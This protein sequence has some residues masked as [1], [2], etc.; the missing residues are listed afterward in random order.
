MALN[1]PLSLPNHVSLPN[2]IAKAAMSEGLADRRTGAPTERLIEL[3]RRWARGGTGLL[4]T[5]NVQIDIDA[6]E[7]LGNVV[8]EDDRHLDMLRA[9]ADAAQADGAALWMQISHAGRQTPRR[10]NPSPVGPSAIAL[11]NVGGLA[12]KPRELTHDEI[13]A[14]IDRF[15]TTAAVAQR[16]GFKG[17]QLHGAHGYLI[18]QFLSPLSNQRTD[19]WGGDAD[20][21]MRFLLEVVRATRR[22]VGHDFPIGV[23]LNSADFQRGG[24]SEDDSANV[25]RALETAGIDLLEISGGNYESP[26]MMGT[27]ELPTEQRESTKRREAYFLT[28]AEKVR[29]I[30]KLPL[31]LTGGMRSAAAMSD[32]IDSGAVDM[33]GLARPLAVEPDLSRRL[34]SDP[35]AAAMTL[36]VRLG[37]KLLDS[38]LQGAWYKRQLHRMADGKEPNPKASKWGALLSAFARDYAFNPF[39][40]RPR[41]RVELPA[42]AP[43]TTA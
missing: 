15:A 8:I 40:R 13:L 6:R 30:T 18:S 17:V 38:M 16:A 42:T 26:A 36:K 27:G 11:E 29:G 31:L 21:R 33:V 9:W 3:Y 20:G 22:A 1:T 32:A 28:Y 35:N 39:R 10:V 43:Q 23:K 5:G 34:L 25:I 4:I 37:V 12:G 2:R 7:A 14:I 19:Q 41:R 24:F